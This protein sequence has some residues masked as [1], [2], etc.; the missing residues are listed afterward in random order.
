M[1]DTRR[2][3]ADTAD[4]RPVPDAAPRAGH[5]LGPLI[6]TVPLDTRFTGRFYAGVLAGIAGAVLAV[7]FSL[8]PGARQ[9]GTHCQLGLPPCGFATVTGLPCPTCGMTTAFAHTVRGQFWSAFRAQPAGFLLALGTMGT[10]VLGIWAMITGRRLT[11]NWYRIS[12]M[13]VTW[14]LVGG[15]VLAWA[16]KIVIGL[17]DGSLPDHRGL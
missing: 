6:H 8:H 15:L 5:T 1:G 10:L 9:M 12:P 2:N 11:V 16:I 17:A 13:S 4:R 14:W 3:H 7:A